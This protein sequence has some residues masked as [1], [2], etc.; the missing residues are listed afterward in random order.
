MSHVTCQRFTGLALLAAV[1]AAAVLLPAGPGRADLVEF[2]TLRGGGGD[3]GVT[4]QT[5]TTTGLT[6]AGVTFDLT[7]TA[8]TNRGGNLHQDNM[9]LGEMGGQHGPE[10][11]ISDLGEQVVLSA[12]VVTNITPIGSTVIVNGFEDLAIGA[13]TGS[14]DVRG[15]V[16]GTAFGP[17]PAGIYNGID[18]DGAGTFAPAL[19]VQWVSGAFKVQRPRLDVTARV[20]PE[21][22]TL[23]LLALAPL[24]ALRRRRR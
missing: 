21:P 24:A 22:A 7:I 23:S 18:P 13:F 3:L 1:A 10:G 15:T 19:D 5:F 17:L 20:V 9:G 12:P 14:L 16:N 6:A 2:T 11:S 8:A 4:T